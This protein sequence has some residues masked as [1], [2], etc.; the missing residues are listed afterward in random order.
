MG[1]GYA[2]SDV[3][4]DIEVDYEYKGHQLNSFEEVVNLMNISLVHAGGDDLVS[5]VTDFELIARNMEELAKSFI[6]Q[7]KTYRTGNLYNSVR[8][9][10][11]GNTVNLNAPAVDKNNHPYAGHIEY[12]FTGRD[13]IPRGPWPFL[14][15]AVRLAAADSRNE[16][17]DSLARFLADE[18][19][20]KGRIAFGRSGNV[21]DRYMASNIASSTRDRF[22]AGSEKIKGVANNRHWTGARHGI[23]AKH[24]DYNFHTSNSISWLEGE[25]L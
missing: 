19:D 1:R 20:M 25:L 14:R 21:I 6:I 4:L 16:I 7:N 11:M 22:G 13:G 24:D 12:G 17:G 9:T 15:P 3:F 8:A 23:R 2:G 18:V 5:K 10:V